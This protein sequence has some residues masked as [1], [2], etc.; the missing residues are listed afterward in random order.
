MHS[1]LAT[2]AFTQLQRYYPI[3]AVTGPRQSGKTTFV[4]SQCVDKPY[5]NLEEPDTRE[6][7]SADP[8]GFLAQFPDGAVLDEVQRVPSLFSYLQAE[9]DRV[10]AATTSRKSKKALPLQARYILTGS[11]QLALMEGVT[12][13][14]A[15]R[16]GFLHLLPFSYAEIRDIKPKKTLEDWLL[17][18]GYPPIY[19]RHIPSQVWH[20][21]YVA[22]YI[23]RDVRQLLNIRDLG[24][25][26]RFIRMCASRTG[27]LLNLSALAADCGITHTTAKA[28]LSILEASYLVFTL[29]PWHTNIGKR[30]VKT[31]KLYFYDTGL[32]AWL[33]GTLTAEQLR[34]S[35]MRGALFENAIVLEVMKAR[36]NFLKDATC[37]FY[38]DSNG[39]EIDLL[40]DFQGKRHAIE[41]KSGATVASDWFQ[42]MLHHQSLLAADTLSL[43][44][45]GNTSMTRQQVEVVAW[46]ALPELLTKLLT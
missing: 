5:A 18:G 32:A 17:T 26:Q 14:L 45:G 39:N 42:P 29:T 36:F 19:D 16:V 23:E 43:I 24:N 38:R 46:N 44:Y 28:W 13:S 41:M 2:T 12:Q 22:T 11:Q 7:A 37:H 30:L 1:R 4:R 34:H 10:Y 6:F 3:V 31:P 25:F 27:Q 40:L 20:R 21:D 9:V 33:A 15:G 8:R 35:S